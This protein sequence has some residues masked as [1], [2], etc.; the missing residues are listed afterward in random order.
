MSAF[1]PTGTDNSNLGGKLALRRHILDQAGFES[2]RVLDLF[3]GEGHIWGRLKKEY[4]VATYLPCDRERRQPAL[5][6]G[7]S[8][9]LLRGLVVSR[10]NVIDVDCYGDPWECWLHIA[11]RIEG[12]TAVFLTCGISSSGSCMGTSVTNWTKKLCG[13]P[14]AWDVPRK[15]ELAVYAAGFAFRAGCQE[16][17]VLAA[18]KIHSG[19]VDYY[20]LLCEGKSDAIGSATRAG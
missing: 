19:N 2:L 1:S 18:G 8:P 3:A 7:D 11:P 12:R 17:N 15:W 10:F 9:R 20:G 14:L 16:T 13:I 4:K 6:L 5:L